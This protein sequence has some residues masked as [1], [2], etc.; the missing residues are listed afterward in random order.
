MDGPLELPFTVYARNLNESWWIKRIEKRRRQHKTKGMPHWLD[1]L[2]SLEVVQAKVH[3]KW[4]R[5]VFKYYKMSG[6]NTILKCLE[7]VSST[8]HWFNLLFN[9]PLDTP[10]EEAKQQSCGPG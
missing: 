9:I 4:C 5:L 1:H 3:K 8:F 10:L 6:T 7:T 2:N